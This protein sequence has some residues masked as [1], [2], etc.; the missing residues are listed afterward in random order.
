MN[1][2]LAAAITLA[3]VVIA[4]AAIL[5]VRRRAPD[6]S[7]FADGDRAAGFFGV[8][9]AGFAILL[10]FVVFLAFESYNQSKSGAETEALIV[11]Q[12]F[13][14]AQFL[15]PAAGRRLGGELVCYARSIVHQEWP[16]MEAGN[17]GDV[18][19][20]WAA[21]QFRSLK[22]ADPS[23]PTQESAFDKWLEQTSGRELARNDRIHAASGVIPDP[24]WVV[25]IFSALMIFAYMLFFADRAERAVVQGMMIGTVAGVIVATLILI[26]FLDNPYHPGYGS[27]KP[28]AMERTLE[29]LD[30][31]REVV[32]D[33]RPPPCDDQGA[34]L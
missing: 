11:V 29:L 17:Q 27:L 1:V 34:P 12:Q 7:Y 3:A 10:G 21:A 28:V 25:L 26:R 22:R 5:L 23:S 16:R 31:A 13:E 15:P 6:G 20:P 2:F 33:Q 24:L 30:Q 19:N 4:V 18:I 14:T 8:L 9:A 32:G